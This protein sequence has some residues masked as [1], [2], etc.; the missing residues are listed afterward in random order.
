LLQDGVSYLCRFALKSSLG[1]FTA[2][3]FNAPRPVASGGGIVPL[4][5]CPEKFSG[6]V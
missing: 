3:G 6:T 2:R 1:L 5:F 4:P